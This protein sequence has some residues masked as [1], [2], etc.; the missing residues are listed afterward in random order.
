MGLRCLKGNRLC[1]RS[2]IE[3]IILITNS[4]TAL[5]KILQLSSGSAW[6]RWSVTGMEREVTARILA[7]LILTP[8]T[9]REEVTE[10]NKG[11][12]P[13]SQIWSKL[14][15]P[16]S[17]SWGSFGDHHD[18]CSLAPQAQWKRWVKR[19]P[20]MWLKK[21]KGTSI[22]HIP[23]EFG[24]CTPSSSAYQPEDVERFRTSLWNGFFTQPFRMGII[25]YCRED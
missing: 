5:T 8:S 25:Q 3:D 22:Q 18:L 14:L 11:F 1:V 15:T 4:C 13:D 6:G 2:R 7:L 10:R 21:R 17:L 23:M 24:D 20:K 16:C 12:S 19:E 9:T